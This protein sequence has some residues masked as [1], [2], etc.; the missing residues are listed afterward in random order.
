LFARLLKKRGGGLAIY[1]SGVNCDWLKA[2]AVVMEVIA[3]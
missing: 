2:L 1:T 3:I